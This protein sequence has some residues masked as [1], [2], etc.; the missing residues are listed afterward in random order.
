MEDKATRPAGVA[1]P[2][3]VSATPEAVPAAAGQTDAKPEPTPPAHKYMQTNRSKEKIIASPRA[4]RIAKELSVD[5]LIMNGSG[6]GGRIVE[7]DVRESA[8]K[9]E[10]R[11]SRLSNISNIGVLAEVGEFVEILERLRETDETLQLQVARYQSLIMKLAALAYSKALRGARRAL[12]VDVAY[13]YEADSGL[14]YRHLAAVN[15]K[16][17]AE[18]S[19]E[20][21]GDAISADPATGEEAFGYIDLGSYGI[22]DYQPGVQLP[23]NI[24]LCSGRLTHAPL[25]GTE[26]LLRQVLRIGISFIE[27]NAGFSLVASFANNL[28]SALKDPVLWI[29]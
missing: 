25:C 21:A 28:H 17:L 9:P 14:T 29:A 6:R 11:A 27:E 23:S 7:R 19:A 10:V 8:S 2:V 20:I 12:T 1:T 3:A 22:D 5:L 18:L 16:T 4:I 26:E 15:R 13:G 24:L